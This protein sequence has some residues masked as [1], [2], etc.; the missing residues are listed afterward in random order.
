MTQTEMNTTLARLEER[1]RAMCQEIARTGAGVDGVETGMA[2]T[3]AAIDR[4][5]RLQDGC[6]REVSETPKC[7][8]AIA[9]AEVWR[10]PGR[11]G[12]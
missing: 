12:P 2:T 4:F 5:S 10:E 11:Q 7:D 1:E 6:A 9:A 3:S 8:A